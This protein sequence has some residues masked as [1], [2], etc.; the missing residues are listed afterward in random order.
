M[1]DVLYPSG[2]GT[3][4]VDIDTLMDRHMPAGVTEPEFRRRARAWVVSHRGRVGFGDRLPRSRNNRVSA[5]SS[6][7][8]S[9]HQLQKFRDGTEWACAID[10]VVPRPGA[11]HS[12]GAV[13]AGLVPVRGSK[14]AERW[15]LHANIGSPGKRGFEPW[16]MQPV[17]L[18]GFGGFVARLRPRPQPGYPL[19]TVPGS[20]LKTPSVAARVKAKV[21]RPPLDFRRGRFGDYPYRKNKPWLRQGSKGDMVQYLQSVISYR[22]GGSVVI[23]GRF[24]PQTE[25][26]VKDLQKFF[27]LTVDGVVGPQTWRTVDA[28]AVK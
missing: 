8:R 10:V 13:P 9:F 5:A 27:G 23:D 1:S 14:D 15:G 12:S 18:D 7:N 26:R 25:R 24:G 20:D 21:V 16:H 17:E 11:G 3:D 19:P 2:Y 4:M 22:A 28:L 6:S